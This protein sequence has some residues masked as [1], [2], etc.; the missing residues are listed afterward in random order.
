[1]EGGAGSQS[2]D[3]TFSTTPDSA[4]EGEDGRQSEAPQAANGTSQEQPVDN[5]EL[6]KRLALFLHKREDESPHEV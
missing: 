2:V 1:M 5:V 4:T 6:E 3:E